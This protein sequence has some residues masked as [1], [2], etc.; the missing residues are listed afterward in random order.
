MFTKK[1][2]FISML[3]T[4]PFLGAYAE[5]T[6]QNDVQLDAMI[7]TATM[8]ETKI[9]D[10]PAFATIVTKDDIAKSSINSVADLLRETVGVNNLS[11][12]SGRDE[13]QIR[14]M[15]GDY[16][17]FLVNGKRVSSGSAFAKGSDA[18]V[19]S[20][21]LN[22]I[23]RIEVIRGPMSVLYG[24]DAI[25][26]VVNVITK[27]PQ[28]GD[29]WT[30]TITAE[31]R[32]I[33]SGED[34]DQYRVGVSGMGAITD[35]LSMS[36]SVEDSSQDAWF[37]ESD[38]NYPL[39]E[40]RNSQNL[41]STLSWQAAEN[42]QV[43]VDFGYNHDERPYQAFSNT[44]YREQEITRTDLAITH[45][46]QWD[47]A[48]TTAYIKR[49][50]S[51]VYDYNTQ[52]ASTGEV[53]HDG[54]ESNNT[55]AKAY[56]NRVLGKHAL[57]GGIDFKQ[58]EL[59]DDYY[60]TSDD[61]SAYQYGLF[62]QDEMALTE[63]LALT[64]GGRLDNHEVYGS[65]FSPKA[66]LVYNL[67]ETLTL[68]GGVTQAFK[69]PALLNYSENYSQASCGGSCLLS[70]NPDLEAETSMSY[71][72]GFD[73]HKKGLGITGAV[74]R[75]D[76]D[77]LIDR[78]VGKDSDGNTEVAWINVNKAMTQGLELSVVTSLTEDLQLK[79]NYTYL[80]TEAEDSDGTKT[81]LTGRPEDQASLS[82]D[83]QATDIL[84]TYATVNYISGMQ[85]SSSG[86]QELPS[87]YRTDIGLVADVTDNLVIRAGIK[88]IGDVRL[89]EEDTNYTTY[90]IGRSFFASAAYNF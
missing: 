57:M 5:A 10:A 61:E 49:E 36:I 32:I 73:Y 55:Y 79:A 1:K 38:D 25:G 48:D 23:E 46:G 78:Y 42:Q 22:S 90:E 16:T 77:N 71:E 41:S 68:K 20:V 40:E 81:V 59:K 30:G 43:D 56:A 6:D 89:D 31:A 82:F 87:Y 14:G 65:N 63:K 72:F 35:K 29:D 60:L 39:R 58:E 2:L 85:A 18:D 24:A 26:G 33:D 4:S 54:L 9:E 51:D 7:V 64:L 75:N 74:F 19:N 17:V 27:K 66:Y 84:G 47:W 53:E 34:G 83:Y 15:D 45:K 62:A 52:Y 21:P 80:D 70:G 11:N 3:A 67:D 28:A 86:D 12:S 13:I 69:A 44:A 37:A 88:N 50:E 76:V 8:A